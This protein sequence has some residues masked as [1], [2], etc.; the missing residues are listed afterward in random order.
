MAKAHSEHE[1]AASRATD[2]A[3]SVGSESVSAEPIDSDELDEH[4]VDEIQDEDVDEDE[5]AGGSRVEEV[6]GGVAKDG[7]VSSDDDPAR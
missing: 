6:G 1:A 3:A 2:G 7:T 5:G 4:D